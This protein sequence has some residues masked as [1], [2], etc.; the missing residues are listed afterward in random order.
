M[1]TQEDIQKILD[2]YHVGKLAQFSD[3]SFYVTA[4]TNQ[5]TYFILSDDPS[6]ARITEAARKEALIQAEGQAERL[7]LTDYKGRRLS[8]SASYAHYQHK[9][10]SVYKPRN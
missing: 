4:H 5:G 6:K 2:H 1:S 7:L 8:E 3:H 9:Y 10:Y